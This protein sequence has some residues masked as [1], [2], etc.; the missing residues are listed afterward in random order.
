M[1]EV[2]INFVKKINPAR[3]TNWLII[4]II[5]YSMFNVSYWKDT[6]RVIHA[7]VISYYAYL[8]SFFIYK[9]I[10][11]DFTNNFNKDSKYI[12]WAKKTQTGKKVIKM[13]MG[14][15][16]LYAPFFF[17][18]H[19]AAGVLN[20][21]TGGY[22]A[23]YVFAL[24]MSCVFY[25][26][27]GLYFLR[28][29]LQQY[30]SKTITAITIAIIVF[31]TNL[32]FYSSFRAPITH[33]YNFSL[34]IVFLYLTIN[35][36]R[37]SSIKNT[38]LLGL[39]LGLITLIRPTNIIVLIF[40]LLWDVKSG[41]EFIERINYFIKYYYLVIIMFVAF[42]IVLTPQVLYWKY[43]T[44]N[45]F[46]YSYGEE[47]FFFANP[48]II[49]GLFSYRN[50]CLLYSPVLI[51]S[52]I[53]IVFLYRKHKEFFYPTLFFVIL[54]T[55]IVL[56]WWCWWYAGFGNRAL[57]DSYAFLAF[58]LA[59]FL[60]WTFKQKNLVRNSLLVL[61]LIFSLLNIYHTIKYYY[62][63]IHPD[64]MTKEAYW[65]S[66]G[67]IRPSSE[68]YQLL[69]KPDYIKAKKGIQTPATIEKNK[70]EE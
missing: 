23:P 58:P 64:S 53:G 28:K 25:L 63:T 65:H 66:F 30:F 5:I 50:G 39:V 19:I 43:V 4:F 24:L 67:K 7:D 60:S 46:C 20:Y 17:M 10:S 27:I 22:S 51:F 37:N 1:L 56:S 21:D 42:I 68:Y 45:Y 48:Q 36:L 54:N 8:P 59:A 69:R 32:F 6:K 44:G 41:K 57:I 9:D 16:I 2:I 40:L 35:W 18:G 15:S 61:V 38:I 70:A 47:S 33:A 55:Y 31:G 26:S 11:L 13:T 14:L 12:I 29:M 52:L 49:K 3:L 34:F 62:K